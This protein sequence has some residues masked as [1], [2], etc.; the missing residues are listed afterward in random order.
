MTSRKVVT[1]VTL[2]VLLVVLLGMA[3]FGYRALTSPLPGQSASASPT[4]SAAETSV[5]RFV[6]RKDITV[7]VF[8]AGAHK[9]RAGDTMTNLEGLGFQPGQVGNA[10]ARVHVKRAVV[11]T[12]STGDA[13][14]ALVAASL[15]AHTQVVV[16]SRDLG[17]GVDV[18]IGP[19]FHRLAPQAPRRML[20]AK[21]RTTCVRV[22]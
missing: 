15:G 19:K 2:G 8:N 1:A 14:A 22:S 10:P 9:G 4:C 6:Y 17:P 21:P 20:L 12:T 11:W 13:G 5:Q 16:T 3:A 18:F 7:S